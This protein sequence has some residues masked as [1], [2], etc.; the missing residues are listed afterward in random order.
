MKVINLDQLDTPDKAIVH[1][2]IT[3]NM[4][5]FTVGEYVKQLKVAKEL[6]KKREQ[7]PEVNDDDTSYI[8]ETLL[9][10]VGEA[11]PALPKSELQEMTLVK[12]NHIFELIRSSTEDNKP[13]EASAGESQ[14]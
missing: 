3:Y 9:E 7:N 11:F 4:K 6:E 12:L 5:S 8:F 10:Q 14:G 1:K 2:G 13:K